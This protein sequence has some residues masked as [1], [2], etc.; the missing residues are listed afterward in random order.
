MEQLSDID[1]SP[2]DYV[3]VMRLYIITVI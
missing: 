2:L 1:P 3:L